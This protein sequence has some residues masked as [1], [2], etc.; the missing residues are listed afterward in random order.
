MQEGRD[1]HLSF[2]GQANQRFCTSQVL[3]LDLLYKSQQ[4]CLFD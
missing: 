2:L 3:S 4:F 1:G